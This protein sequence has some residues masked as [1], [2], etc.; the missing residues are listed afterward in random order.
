[1][2]MYVPT[3]PVV[4]TTAGDTSKKKLEHAVYGYI[5]A[6]RAL[7]IKTVGVSQIAKALNLTTEQV[8]GT[9]EALKAKGVRGI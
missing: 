5:R 7:D 1:M 4:S 3:E 2:M 6:I 8:L 9:L